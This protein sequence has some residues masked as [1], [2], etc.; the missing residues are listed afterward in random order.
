MP[1]KIDALYSEV[2]KS[3]EVGS[4]DDF[5][6]YLADPKKRQ[7][8]FKEVIAPEYDVK[9]IDDFD[10]AYGFKKKSTE[11]L[12]QGAQKDIFSVSGETPKAGPSAP[13][14]RKS[15]DITSP[16]IIP[17]VKQPASPQ[18][19]GY[20]S[21]L[22]LPGSEEKKKEVMK[23]VE[24]S[25]F[26][27]SELGKL[28]A[29]TSEERAKR[30][31]QAFIDA[32][33]P[34]FFL[35]AAVDTEK[36]SEIPN[37]QRIDFLNDQ[38]GSLGF[39]FKKKGSGLGLA[40]N[41]E[42]I[43]DEGDKQEFPSDQL[44]NPLYAVPLQQFMYD[45]SKG[46]EKKF[47]PERFLQLM[48][49]GLA[50][51]E[52]QQFRRMYDNQIGEYIVKQANK[53]VAIGSNEL[54]VIND[55]RKKLS[56]EANKISIK[57]QSTAIT[58]DERARHDAIVLELED[59]SNQFELKKGAIVK[60]MDLTSGALKMAAAERAKLSKDEGGALDAV[61]NALLKGGSNIIVGALEA[62]ITGA[63]ASQDYTSVGFLKGLQEYGKQNLKE[64]LG[65]V[66]P[67]YIE[68]LPFL[69]QA[70]LSVAETLPA[71][72][73][74]VSELAL[75]FS[76]APSY[77]EK[78]DSSP[79]AKD[80]SENE[81]Y[82]Y[83][84]T[85]SYAQALLEK[86]GFSNAVVKGGNIVNTVT[87][88]VLKKVLPKQGYEGV[89]KLVTL[90]INNV[91]GRYLGRTA[92]SVLSEAETGAIQYASDIAIEDIVNEI[93]GKD[94]FKNEDW[95]S[96][97]FID[98]MSYSAAMEGAGGFILGGATNFVSEA[99]YQRGINKFEKSVKF[100]SDPVMSKLYL[101]NIN[102]AVLSGKMTKEE[103]E[104]KKSDMSDFLSTLKMMPEGL[105]KKQQFDAFSLLSEKRKLT[106]QIEGKDPSLVNKQKKRIATIDNELIDISNAVQEQTTSEV[107]VQSEA[108]VGE[109]VVEGKPQP[110]P[111]VVTEEGKEKVAI[112][113]GKRLFNE[114]NP[115]TVEI[116]K[117]YKEKN[118]IV[119]P[120]GV[121]IEAVDVDNASKIADAYEAL[122]DTPND[123][124]VQ[125]A[126]NAMADETAKQHQDIV[127]AGYEVEIWQGEGEPYANAQEMIDDVKNN[128]HMFIYST[129]QGFGDAPITEEQRKQN[130]LLQES[131][132]KDKTGKP[133]LYNDL[134]RF[135]HDFFGH[136]ERGNG[137]GP[138]GEEN[139]WD[140][141][142]RMYTPKARRAMTTETRGQNSWVNFGPQMR[143][144]EGSLMKKGD[145][146]Y[147]SPQDRKFAPQ[148]MALM[149]EEFSQITEV[150]SNF[151]QAL[152][153]SAQ[154]LNVVAPGLRMIVGENIDD[155]QNQIVEVLAP[156]V[157][158]RQAV[159]TAEEFATG[160]K[161]QTIFV[162]GKPVALVF[163]KS[164]ADSRTIGHEAW[165]AML[166]D[167]FGNDQ[168][169]FKEFTV[170]IDSQLRAQGFGDIADALD[171]FASQKGYEAVKYSEYMAELGGMLVESGFGKGPLTAQQKTLLQK[172]GDIVN[173]FAELFT[174]KK[175]FLDQATPE[176]I[177]GFMV[178]ISEKVAKGE[179]V[180][181]F[182]R[183][184]EKAKAKEGVTSKSQID[185]RLSEP[186][187]EVPKNEKLS[188]KINPSKEGDVMKQIDALL[189]KY[190]NAL[191]DRNQWKEL[192]SRVF[193]Y[194]GPNG[195]VMIP[196]FPEALSRMSNSVDEVL[197]ELS[198]VSDKQR[199]L[200]SSG[201]EGTKEIGKLYKEGK[202]DETDTGL[203]FLWNIMSIGI[204]PYPQ[205]A[206]FLR[207]VENGV[208][209][210]IKK[211]AEGKFLSGKEIDYKG[212]K[213]D[214]GLADYYDWVD[215]TLPKGVAGSG[216][217]ANLRSFGSAFLSKASTKIETGE[218][219]GLTK[220]ESLHKILSDRTTPT[221]ELRRKWLSNLSGMSFNNKIFD[222]ILLTTGRSDLFV[223][224]RVRTEHFWDSDKLKKDSGLKPTTSIYDGSELSFGKTT[225]AG[226]SKMLSD[227][228]GLVFAELANRTMQPVVKEAYQK[229]G[230][231][232]S[233]DVGRFHWETWVAASSQEVSHGS[234]DAIV[235]RKASGEIT[236][237]GI[238]QGKYGAWD[239]N[240][241][242]RKRAGKPFMYEFTDED[243]SVYEFDDIAPIYEEISNQNQKKN[244]GNDSDRFILKDENGNIIKRKTEKIDNAWYDQPGV[245]K[246]KYFDYL[247]SQAK[248]VIPAPNVIEDQGVVIEKPKVTSRSQKAIDDIAKNY[249]NSELAKQ[250]GNA[251]GSSK[252]T[253]DGKDVYIQA[254]EFPE[255]AS[256][257][258]VIAWSNKGENIAFANFRQNK[259]GAWYSMQSETNKSL[260][261]KGV[262]TAIYNLAEK[263]IG[264]IVESKE[265]TPEVKA[266]WA[267]RKSRSQKNVPPVVD[268]VLTDDGK[269]NYLFVHYSRANRDVIKPMSGSNSNFT[270]REEVSAIS[271]VGGVAMY[272]TKA[273][274]KE[275]G[276]G[277]VPH[278]VLVPKDK[279]YFY[280]STEKG[281][282]SHD[283]EGFEEEARQRF[284]AYR[285]RGNEDRPT[286]YAFDAN[287]SAAW[288]TKVAAENG[289]D[290][291][292]TNWGGPKSYRAQ[293]TKALKPEAEYTGF[294]IPE[295]VVFEVGDEISLYGRY[296]TIVAVDGDVL[297][298]ES[299][300]AFG[301]FD[302][303]KFTLSPYT[304]YK[305]T[306]IEKAKPSVTTRSQ[307][308]EVKTIP[309][310]DRMMNEVEGIMDKTIN[311]GGSYNQA[312][313]NAINY[314]Q[315]SASYERADDSQR[316][317]IIRDFKKIRGEKFKVAPS[318]AKI[319]GQIEDVKKIT[320][321]ESTALKDQIKLEAKAA[322]DSA[323]FV[324]Q[325]R[326]DI[327]GRL[328]SMVGRGMMSARQ[329]TAI[330]SRYDKMNILNPVM[331]DRFVDYMSRVF[332]SAE[333]MDK[334]KEASKLRA[335]IKK[336]MKSAA[337]Q[338][339]IAKLAKDFGDIDPSRVENIDDYI[340]NAT[341]MLNAV[342][343]KTGDPL[344]RS[345][346]N[347]ADMASY[348]ETEIDLQVEQIK[349][350]LLDKYKELVDAGV[351]SSDMTINE[352]KKV[353]AAI[354]ENDNEAVAK[355]EKARAA[356]KE[357]ME[358][359]S[360]L[361][362]QIV[363]TGEDPFTG[364]PI[365]LT[366][367]EKRSLVALANMDTD[368]LSLSS[369]IQVLE[370]ANNFV[371][372]GI[373]SGIDGMVSLYQGD[374]NA[375]DLVDDGIKSIPLS[376]YFSKFVGKVWGEGFATLPMLNKLLWGNTRRAITVSEKAGINGVS[377][378]KAKALKMVDTAVK[379]YVKQFSKVKD[380]LASENVV[381]RG[382]FAFMSRNVIGDE[383]QA[384]DEFNRR[385]SL[386]EE[387][388]QALTDVDNNT[389]AE[390]KK[391]EVI[392]KVYDKVLKDAKNIDDVKKNVSQINQD[393]VN[394][395]IN[396]WSENFDRLD[397]VSRNVYNT[398]LSRDIDF[399]PDRYQLKEAP[400]ATEE[401]FDSGFFGNFE[402]VDTSKSGSLRKNNRIAN[403]PKDKNGVKT[404]IVNLD[405]DVNNV[406]AFTNA[407]VDVETASSVMQMK[408][409]VTSKNFSKLFSN[410]EDKNLYKKRLI[411]YVNRAKG[412]S[413]ID[414]NE[415]AKANRIINT[416]ASFGVAKALFSVSQPFK[417]FFPPMINTFVQTGR[418]DLN[419]LLYGGGM[420]FID[421]SGYPIANRGVA[422]Q[423]ELKS[424]NRQ[425]VEAE[426]N[427]AMRGLDGVAEF[428]NKALEITLKNPDIFAARASWLS[429]YLSKLKKDG[430]NISGIDFKNH[431]LNKAAADYAQA[432]VDSQQNIS[433]TDMQGEI[434]ASK[435]PAT[436]FLRRAILPL[437]TFTLNQ[438]TRIWS[439]V[440]TLSND[441]SSKDDKRE[442]AK[443]LSGALVEL[444]AFQG[445]VLAFKE[446]Y[447]VVAAAIM[448]ED[449]DE[450]Q[451]KIRKMR[452]AQ[453][454]AQAFMKDFFLPPIPGMDIAASKGINYLLDETGL[455]DE[456]P[457][458]WYGIEDEEQKFRLYDKMNQGYLDMLGTQGIAAE[459]GLE[460]IDYYDAAID[461]EFTKE[462]NGNKVK[463]A[464][465]EEDLD[466]ARMNAVIM[467]AY[468]GGL[469]PSDMA[470][471]VN[472]M[473]KKIQKRAEQVDED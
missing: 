76:M 255:N 342:A 341:Q 353:V 380:F 394:W 473:N 465:M 245:D 182:F 60:S 51:E 381:E 254:I 163:D 45:R 127:D 73:A 375:G 240:F 173:K 22:D 266:F 320:V 104:K 355:E 5:K 292:V 75:T 203:Y 57:S 30:N 417:Q 129:E 114:P 185:Q 137:F 365:T 229:I 416:I 197:K 32:R 250:E 21:F 69:G 424:I 428:S 435:Q 116:S 373:T 184:G 124:E 362:L 302:T 346:V 115:E 107:P 100:A 345:L 269:G 453:S 247:K 224:D 433:D 462:Y 90:E 19:A 77:K 372:N 206:G 4:I 227:V 294:K 303:G 390:I 360:P 317:Q 118:N 23:N 216:S 178:T 48:E 174:G 219:K 121:K 228:P 16:E 131:G 298:Y 134:F 24:A 356:V 452:Q 312:S 396:K 89:K 441:V 429:F 63:T 339:E 361:I 135:V 471:I 207:A 324:K 238:R 31:L 85:A 463:K 126:Y 344:M 350:E 354:E 392:Q 144:A 222:F 326:M 257:K 293:T 119:E 413:Y 86:L 338:A 161:G 217:K 265:Q 59:L 260:Q 155:V 169:R 139:A 267:K 170:G 282:V 400:T 253:V 455:S 49:G 84:W 468:Y 212:E 52:E 146:G 288:V 427:L 299:P 276:V 20:S 123:P 271:A 133:L 466:I 264:K 278:T 157:G 34:S 205:E 101:A 156:L 376:K 200:A 443:S 235:Q 80:M 273:G 343:R 239:F 351:L 369:A 112:P 284:Q 15:Y 193:S 464:L 35:K 214:S 450:E 287:N 46:K 223:I 316:E 385:K 290:M 38:Y 382:V 110:E 25:L 7:L 142:A 151:D 153:N 28:K 176:D 359:V 436:V 423:G 175:Q 122:Q 425:L 13:S 358:E 366:Q 2:S 158:E 383:F 132:F 407:M 47:T 236:D 334:I 140:V 186:G 164:T 166:N 313:A 333:Y 322:R 329:A 99:Q 445:I 102:T 328:K 159:Q 183:K 281:T 442:A 226:Y 65:D 87:F 194:K 397:E 371:A 18:E 196:K 243:G 323:A 300:N 439:D 431:E 349:N 458:K 280:G 454:T 145:Q 53:N 412:G 1:N 120:E 180:A 78:V 108:R 188:A 96:K 459:K 449:E 363:K 138:V 311:R 432:M 39:T 66:S 405:F 88:N 283:P 26:K 195:E 192:M 201:L 237:A 128:K 444:V 415:L 378:G 213:I 17:N 149:P 377:N 220:M 379:Q 248:E 199:E 64:Y 67:E 79:M 251:I 295:P 337:N 402:Y 331:R 95:G 451:K 83:V 374:L 74:P 136:T 191:K 179:D 348:I 172:I 297:T 111:E 395:W 319:L 117:T 262:M 279:V 94:I 81:K 249:P 296:A 275:S 411:K 62:L 210:F 272:Y 221:N 270:S 125:D 305:I 29:E 152:A 406:N 434:F 420:T 418:F 309:G 50:P 438:K 389:D 426:K 8:F 72:L 307:K 422:S 208:D 43:S 461:G 198:K 325:L 93:K 218:F 277:D 408:G 42:V 437:M 403:L 27:S 44:E 113:A 106:Q 70:G 347:A 105:G 447:N 414:Q 92:G 467:T 9:S 148:K 204:S 11:S 252:I 209:S 91:A 241:A 14:V 162:D 393:A 308:V 310:Y 231:K 286:K 6:K 109:E 141:H 154:S 460:L 285:N 404:R 332:Q 386:I 202:M 150:V 71:L 456:L 258:P 330:I 97:E 289:Y 147:L 189:D 398:Q 401:D 327:S 259:D 388:I 368:N 3:Y 391:G 469:L 387:T 472:I 230:V 40:D 246:Q 367:D 421:S 211:S 274:Q 410:K 448:G 68:D 37:N 167:A 103:G 244:Y 268:E 419:K 171:A 55:A 41:I 261:R 215:Q 56:E 318:V 143:N 321:K 177:L 352:I 315:K 58:A 12:S 61:K 263:A 370:Y 430:V 181:S 470:N 33:D 187:I 54:N 336:N 130:K 82:A 314:I 335:S 160:T 340:N 225:G 233:P 98:K 165:E 168:A 10:E 364:E 242:Y 457:Y 399:T 304:S 357:M 409:F 291:L 384:Q 440:R 446:L 190:P 232:D 256:V 301:R 306:M 36:I 234:I